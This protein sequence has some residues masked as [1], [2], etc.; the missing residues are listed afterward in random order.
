MYLLGKLY[1]IC[2][3]TTAGLQHNPCNHYWPPSTNILQQFVVHDFQNQNKIHFFKYH[4]ETL[5]WLTSHKT[6]SLARNPTPPW[7]HLTNV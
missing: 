4:L 6:I 5:L 7:I 2:Q 3:Y 1:L